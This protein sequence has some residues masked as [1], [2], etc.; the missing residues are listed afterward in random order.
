[1]NKSEF[2]NKHKNKYGKIKTILSIWSFKRKRFPCV[3]LM[4]H[5]AI[6]C[7]QGGMKKWG[8]NYW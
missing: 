6:I 5:K 7:E 1:M 3:I 2:N 4:K 8:V